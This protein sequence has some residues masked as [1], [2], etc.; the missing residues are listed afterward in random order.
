[1]KKLKIIIPAFLIL[2][3][4]GFISA[5]KTKTPETTAK[6]F[7]AWYLRE[8]NNQGNPVDERATMRKYISRRLA[9]WIYSKSYEEYG[10]DYFLDAQDWD[11]KWDI[12]AS[13]AVVRGN[14]AALKVSLLVPKGENSSIMNSVLRLKMI[15]ENG[16]WKIDEVN[17]RKLT[18]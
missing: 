2:F 9:N 7:Y 4:A 5:Q 15:K 18:E 10:A 11:E 3:M 14:K 12:S 13:K 6:D 8:L 16:M 1:M 17:D